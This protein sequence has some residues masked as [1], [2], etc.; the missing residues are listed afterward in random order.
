MAQHYRPSITFKGFKN[1]VKD[2]EDHAV[3]EELA[4][5]SYDEDAS[6]SIILLN[7]ISNELF[8]ID[9]GEGFTED[10]IRIAATLG[11]GDKESRPFSTKKRHYLGSYGV[12]L[13]STLNISS[14]IEIISNSKD[15]RF[16]TKIDWTRLEEILKD[17]DHEGY[18]YEVE[19]KQKSHGTGACIR[20]K[21]NKSTDKSHL[22]SYGKA[23]GNLPSDNGNFLCYFGLYED[24]ASEIEKFLK[25]FK[26]LKALSSKLE[27]SGKLSLS[28]NILEKDL[29]QCS[30]K[31]YISGDKDEDG[32]KATIYFAGMNGDKVKQLKN[33][34]RGIYV[35]IHG[36]LLKHNF[37][38]SDYTYNISR[39]M[40]FASGLRV[41]LDIN[42]LRDHITLSRDGLTFTN[43]KLKKDFTKI[44]QQSISQFINPKLKAIKNKKT[45]AADK[46][47]ETRHARVDQRLKG[48]Q[49]TMVNGFKNGFRY[50]PETDAELA[51]LLA[52]QP[53]IL[54]KA[55]NWQLLDY[56]DQGG[57]DCIFYNPKLDE[58]I[59]VELEP[60]LIEFLSHNNKSGIEHIV[61]WKRGAWKVNT[62]K[63]GKPG[64]LQLIN[65]KDKGSGFYRLLEFASE[66]SK[67][68][69]NTYPTL[70]LEEFLAKS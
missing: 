36:R 63:K 58:K 67:E 60:T 19:K 57:F 9:D 13:K 46:L 43:P 54:K 47:T 22:K 39:Y 3:I 7:S 12:G 23:L 15:G 10:K 6:T 1:A 69:R 62:S 65:D 38:E 33:P 26:G 55:G 14:S 59:Q 30:K 51:I 25:T 21:L 31:E 5:N 34:L 35:R 50:I 49:A 20:L 61:T 56:N 66:K 53:E 16:T 70:V 4:A 44:V 48:D 2:Y 41:E 68:P 64:F 32:Y 24:V 42:W 52:A 29:N 40:K 8:I 11:G 18:K 17:P 27:K 45:K 28:T 37:S